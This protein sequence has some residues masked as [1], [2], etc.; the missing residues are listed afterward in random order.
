ESSIDNVR[1]IGSVNLGD[2]VRVEDGTSIRGDEGVPISI[3]D[4]ARIGKNNTFHS[5]NKKVIEI[6]KD[7]KLGSDAVIHGP[8]DM[9]DNVEVGNRAIVFKS[10]IGNNV[11]IGNNAVVTGVRL[12]DGAVIPPG[13]I[14]GSQKDAEKFNDA[15]R[16]DS[17]K[18]PASL[19]GFIFAAFIP[20]GL[21][22]V[23]SV[24]LRDRH[25]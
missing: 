20:A 4:N 17:P 14:V 10:K 9:G 8:L 19:F 25:Q 7:F 12:L 15:V 18:E 13:T 5:L 21:G 6:G 2:N 24:A 16:K 11:V 3:G 22:L 1:I 23:G